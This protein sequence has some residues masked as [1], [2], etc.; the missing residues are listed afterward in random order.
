MLNMEIFNEYSVVLGTEKQGLFKRPIPF[1]QVISYNPYTANEAVK[2]YDVDGYPKTP[3]IFL[4]ANIGYGI[5]LDNKRVLLTPYI[6]IGISY[7]LW[8]IY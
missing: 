2:S 4:S 3:R 8:T 5:G 1:A 6:G 7:N